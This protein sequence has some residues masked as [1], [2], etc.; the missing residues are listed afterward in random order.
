MAGILA[1]V[2]FAAA[3][4]VAFAGVAQAHAARYELDTVAS[5]DLAGVPFSNAP[6]DL[7]ATGD[8]SNVTLLPSP[9]FAPDTWDNFPV[10]LAIKLGG[11]TLTATGPNFAFNTQ[12]PPTVGVFGVGSLSYSTLIV[13]VN[14]ALKH[15]RMLTSI[16]PLGGLSIVAPGG[17]QIAT[18]AGLLTL[19]SGGADGRFVAVVPEPATWA[20]MI[21]GLGGVGAAVR[22]RRAAA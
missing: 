13:F 2:A 12:S 11:T 22:R 15:F 21:L 5:G 14:S 1:K 6:I 7:V 10:N 17:G 16:G 19:T 20:I 8:T 9:P 18:G 3:M 4:G